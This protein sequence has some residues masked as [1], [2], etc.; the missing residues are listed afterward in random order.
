MLFEPNRNNNPKGTGI[1]EWYNPDN[2]KDLRALAQLYIDIIRKHDTS[3]SIIIVGNPNWS[4]RPEDALS[5]L[6]EYENIMYTYH[7]YT[8]LHGKISQHK[9]DLLLSLPVFVTEWGF[10]HSQTDIYYAKAFFDWMSVNKISWAKWALNA[11]GGIHTTLND[12]KPEG[13]YWDNYSIGGTIARFNTMNPPDNFTGGVNGPFE[14]IKEIVGDGDIKIVPEKDLYDFDENV[15]ISAVPGAGMVF[16]GWLIDTMLL[17]SSFN[18]RVDNT[19]IF[20]AIFRKVGDY[21]LNGEF[22][23]DV[24]TWK[25]HDGTGNGTVSY[26]DG[27]ASIKISKKTHLTRAAKFYQDEKTLNT[28]KYTLS[29]DAYALNDQVINVGIKRHIGPDPYNLFYEEGIA[30]TTVKTTYTFE[31]EVTADPKLNKKDV[32]NFEIG[33]FEDTINFDNISLIKQ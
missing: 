5:N 31:V 1:V 14:I 12:F 20:R 9:R 24:S 8:D 15:T 27:E 2:P 3:N 28:G 6:L 18:F 19:S 4:G 10:G 11:G 17:D 7:Y 22:L 25:L 32:L 26:I 29:F 21:V 23:N 30:V 13:P 33:D 16:D